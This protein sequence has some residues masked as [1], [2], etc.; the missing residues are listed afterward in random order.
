MAKKPTTAEQVPG[1]IQ[2]APTIAE[3]L[4]TDFQAAAQAERGPT[5]AFIA[6]NPFTA[7]IIAFVLGNVIGI[8]LHV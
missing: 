1:D 7:L 8:F 5:R 6:A 4:Q 2:S 3:T